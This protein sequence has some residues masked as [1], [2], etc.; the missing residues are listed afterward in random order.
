M[1]ILS[2][3][4]SSSGLEAAAFTHEP[5]YQPRERVGV[6]CLVKVVFVVCFLRRDLYIALAVL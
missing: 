4:L 3:K 2:I 1:W 5:S 6:V